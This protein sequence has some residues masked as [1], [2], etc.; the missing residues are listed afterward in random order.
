MMSRLA[1][2]IYLTG[3]ALVLACAA[4]SRAADRVRILIL[5]GDTD[6]PYHDWRLT[7]P[8]LRRV[9]E[10]TGRFDVKVEEEVNGITAATL[11]GF[12]VLALNYNGPRWGE[13][14]ERA[15]EAFLRSGKGMIALHGVSYGPF[16]GQDMARRRMAGS[17]WTAYADMLGMTWKLE[18]VGHSVR[19]VFPVK[20]VDRNHP[21]SRGLD[22]DFL[23]NDELYHKMDLKPNA[24]VLATAYSD[25]K[26]GGTG[27]D[28][29][30][31]WTVPFG[32]G[33]VVHTS[34]GHDLSAMAQPGFVQVFARGAEWAATGAVTLPANLSAYPRANR[35]PIRVLAVTGGHTYPTAFYT[36][37]EGYRDIE[38]AHAPSQTEAFRAGM[39]A[40]WD[41]LVLHDCYEKLGEREQAA[42]KAFVDSGKGV[43][44]IHHSIV[45]YTSWPWWY[46]EVIGGKYFNQAE[47][48]HPASA[49]KEGVE[50][51]ARPVKGMNNHPVLRGVGPIP[52][53][54]EVYKGMW[55]SP[56]IKVLMDTDS[57]GNDSPV[58]YLGPGK[59]RSVYIQPGHESATLRHPGYRLLVYN[60]IR[61]AAGRE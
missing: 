36:L 59:T 31:V 21:I 41:V 44:S 27:K 15:V 24:H 47:P 46:E 5:T 45:D 16:Y 51:L 54:D 34:L 53:H 3:I 33:R 37:F 17:P 23:A 26:Q 19:H 32:A 39:E 52:A 40:R 6:L 58:V 25:P 9:L 29:P 50:L 55:R 4:L 11:A 38:W 48:G 2:P 22:E 43:V 60:A 30:M 35:D 56:G 8:F 10:D 57:P 20:W 61:W 18:N 13:E 12:D 1:F 28:E 14:T 42:L 7:T 49:Y